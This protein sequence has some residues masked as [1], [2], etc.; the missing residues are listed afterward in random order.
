MK[1]GSWFFIFLF[2]FIY[3]A[4][5]LGVLSDVAGVQ[6][7]GGPSSNRGGDGCSGAAMEPLFLVVWKKR[8]TKLSRTGVAT[9]HDWTDFGCVQEN[10]D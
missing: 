9:R 4:Q 1:C 10:D 3:E 8:I 6:K 2:V 7:G 5:K